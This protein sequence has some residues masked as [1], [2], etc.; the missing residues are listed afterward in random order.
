MRDPA[1]FMGWKMIKRKKNDYRYYIP[2][3]YIDSEVVN[4]NY[5]K[6]EF[7]LEEDFPS[8]SK[9][10]YGVYLHIG[11]R[12]RDDRLKQTGKCGLSGLIWGKK[13]IIEFEEYIKNNYNEFCHFTKPEIFILIGWDDNKRRNVYARGLKDIGFYFKYIGNKKYLVK[14]II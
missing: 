1:F 2:H 14:Q 12:K 6:I 3:E 7:F 13:K 8:E 10:Y 4:G 9:Y 11:K 5:C